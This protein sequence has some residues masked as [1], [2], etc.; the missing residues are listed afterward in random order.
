MHLFNK[1]NDGRRVTKG[2]WNKLK[3]FD[4]KLVSASPSDKHHRTCVGQ[5][6]T[7]LYLPAIVNY[8]K[9]VSHL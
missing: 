9:T 4:K 2:P 8:K 3:G 1:S 6:I 5:C 7:E